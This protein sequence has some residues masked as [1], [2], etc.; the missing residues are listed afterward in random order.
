MRLII[1]HEKSHRALMMNTLD[2]L[3]HRIE[4]VHMGPGIEHVR[5]AIYP[6]LDFRSPVD[7]R[8]TW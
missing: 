2:D 1:M 7:K 3:V 4:L 8:D 5:T 6:V